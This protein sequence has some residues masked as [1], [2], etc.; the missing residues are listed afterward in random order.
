MV[1]DSIRKQAKH[2]MRS[3]PVTSTTPWSL[4]QLL[5][6]GSCPFWVLVL[7]SFSNEQQCRS[8]SWINP[9]FPRLFW[10]WCFMRAIVTLTVGHVVMLVTSGQ[11]ASGWPI[12][13]QN[14]AIFVV[15]CCLAFVETCSSHIDVPSIVFG[16]SYSRSQVILVECKSFE[17]SCRL[18][19]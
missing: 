14:V 3:K 18:N 17:N 6:P 16:F 13:G 7:T 19:L 12:A 11:A 5:S 2:T 8:V 1:L 10:P 4:H 9:F 15:V